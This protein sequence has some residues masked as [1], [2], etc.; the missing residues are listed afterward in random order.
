MRT[1]SGTTSGGVGRE[2]AQGYTEGERE[3]TILR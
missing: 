3:S 2:Q 1:L